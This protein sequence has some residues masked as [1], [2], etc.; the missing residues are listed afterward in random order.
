LVFFNRHPCALLTSEQIVAFVGYEA[1][2]VAQSIDRLIAARV[3]ERRQSPTPHAGRLYVVSTAGPRG[4]RLAKLLQVVS[5]RAGRSEALAA[6]GA[7]R[8]RAR[9]NSA[10]SG[11]PHRLLRRIG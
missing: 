10:P 6:L 7:R 1:G 8:E 2:V 4:G 11:R 5:T 3:L 9:A